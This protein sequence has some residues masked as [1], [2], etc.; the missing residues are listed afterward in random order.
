MN[1]GALCSALDLYGEAV[2]EAVDGGDGC[3]GLFAA[4]SPRVR[5]YEPVDI[6]RHLV[7]NEKYW[8]LELPNRW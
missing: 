1:Q 4:R 3:V 5:R 2:G 8:V 6:E 7:A